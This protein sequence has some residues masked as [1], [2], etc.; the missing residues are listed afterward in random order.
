M[1]SVPKPKDFSFPKAEERIGAFWK[2]INAF[3]TSV[4]KS[5]G[6][7][8]YTFYDGPPFATGTPHY[9]HI[10]AGTIKDTVTRFYHQ[11]GHYISR[12]FGWDCHGLPIEFEI[13]KELGIKTKEQVLE[14]GIDNYNRACRGIV[15]RY[16]EEWK[17]VVTRLGRWI[18]MENNYKTMDVSFME[19]VWWVFSELWKKGLVYRGVKVM[20]YST[21]CT[22]V[23]SN[24]EASMNYKEVSDP[25][26]YVAFQSVDDPNVQYIA[27]TTT[28]WT[29]PSNLALCVHPDFDY[30]Q[31]RDNKTGVN[32]V[33]AE[34]R[35]EAIY[36]SPKKSKKPVELPY[37]VV[38]KVK[39]VDLK[40]KKYVPLFNYFTG[41]YPNAFRIITATYVTSTTGTG[42]VHQAPAFGD[43]D[44]KATLA[45]GVITKGG[46]IPC[47]VDE[48][49]RF[50]AQVTDYAGRYIKD[51]D[52]DIV[53]HLKK[54]GR[55]FK[56]GKF[57]H[58]YPYC[59]RSDTPLIYKA[60]PSWFV[61]VEQAKQQLLDN[62]L[63]THWVPEFVQTK[64]FH[65]WLSEA[66][67]WAISR[68]RYW[69]TP[70][71][72]W[73][74]AD[75]EEVVVISSIE[76]LK[77]LSGVEEI[78]DLHRD[79]IDNITIPSSRG[80]APLRRV[81]DVFDC[82]FESGSM[83]YAQNHYPFENQA[84]F[85]KNFPADFIAEGIDQTRG[86]FY[87][88]LV[89]STLLFDKPPFKNLIV[90]G[91]VLT[92]D[93][94]KMSKRLKNYPDP[95]LVID[96][97]G[98]DA[99]RMYLINSPVVRGDNLC[100]K[101]PGVY[102]IVRDMLLP[103]YNNLRFLVQ[104]VQEY[105]SRTGTR[106][107]PDPEQVFKSTNIIDQW[108]LA[109]TQD[110]IA[111]IHQELY[112]YRLYT[113]LPKLVDYIQD[114]NNWYVRMNRKRFRGHLG[115]ED[116][117]LALNVLFDTLLT[118]TK[119]MAPFTPFFTEFIYQ[120]LRPALPSDAEESVH[121]LDY[122]EPRK[123][124]INQ[125]VLEVIRVMQSIIELGRLTR[126]RRRY[127]H[128]QPLSEVL[129]SLK[130][131]AL[132]TTLETELKEYILEE[133]NVKKF[134]FIS[135]DSNLYRYT[136]KPN[137]SVLGKRLGKDQ[138]AVV[139]AIKELS[140]EQLR[141]YHTTQ[142]ITVLNHELSGTDIEVN[143]SINIDPAVYEAS[144]AEDLSLHPAVSIVMNVH[145][146]EDLIKEGVIRNV[147]HA[148]QQLRKHCGVLVSDPQEI[149]YF[150]SGTLHE[151]LQSWAPEIS[152]R[153]GRSFTDGAFKPADSLVHGHTTFTPDVPLYAN[154]SVAIQVVKQTYCVDP[155]QFETPELAVLVQRFLSS[156]SQDR[157][158]A[159][160][161][162]GAYSLSV[163]GKPV[164]L[165][166]GE[167][168]FVNAAKLVAH[169][170]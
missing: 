54:S 51:A 37:T 158:A 78:T 26:L 27:W 36:P 87:T 132:Q 109:A 31:V 96:S 101:E 123:E 9:G 157:L 120:T 24:F 167:N 19:S 69:G 86:W 84:R 165:T 112:A 118:I 168:V 122:P 114:L 130:N 14:Y 138:K 131:P 156:N 57:A 64:R 113:V 53:I 137:F 55:V 47:P 23:L 79:S 28:P 150:T 44:Y 92:E 15:M 75:F 98:A 21:G 34:C 103:W 68:T 117:L 94:K 13:E 40:D 16:S 50:T 59:W 35:L 22:T 166:L 73:A 29:L 25:E 18:D 95:S 106:F 38:Q 83:P 116:C 125:N 49:G 1:K 7:P 3:E 121:Y 65:N 93:G 126:E 74:S 90:N 134:S 76:E 56:S 39:G 17:K 108:I 159:T 2:E 58:N 32:Y 111:F 161:A 20:P 6:K 63:K 4:K 164:K 162:Q 147:I 70:L 41:S 97:Y 149:F 155:N 133:L 142:K 160:F 43:D 127:A 110:L 60:V 33:V 141:E 48:S 107:T 80:G 139:T 105:E 148:I 12:R 85:E 145:L 129:I 81:E 152:S 151:L 136:V 11:K 71:P 124:L 91:L 153:I 115:E 77:R 128:R 163:N 45:A 88:L 42:I 52:L 8:E 135:S 5:E 104:H 154:Q 170:A 67:D 143:S 46:P 72:I 169:K 100:F 62:N 30:V 99:L 66:H 119:A 10:L 89:L 102:G 146:T 61:S 144:N 82:W 140:Q